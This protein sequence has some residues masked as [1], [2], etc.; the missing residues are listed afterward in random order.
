MSGSRTALYDWRWDETARRW[1]QVYARTPQVSGL[2]I[3]HLTVDWLNAQPFVRW[4]R[5]TRSKF[6]TNIILLFS[7]DADAPPAP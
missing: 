5:W 7:R 2:P 6:H 4:Q 3:T 1:V